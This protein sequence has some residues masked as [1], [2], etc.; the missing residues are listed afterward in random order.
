MARV[1][2]A[3]LLSIYVSAGVASAYLPQQHMPWLES[4]ASIVIV[5][6]AVLGIVAQLRRGAE[7]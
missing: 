1:I 7:R 6:A 4:I 2:A 3:L 5:I